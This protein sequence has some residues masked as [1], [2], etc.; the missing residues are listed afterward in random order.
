MLAFDLQQRAALRGPLSRAVQGICALVLAVAVAVAIDSFRAST[1]ALPAQTATVDRRPAGERAVDEAQ[2]RLLGA[3]E[4]PAALIRLA[5]AYLLRARETG[6]P[7]YY[8]RA[9]E[10]LSRS[11]PQQSD[12][13]ETTVALGGLALARHEFEEALEWGMQAIALGPERPSAHGILA[14]ALVELGRYDQAVGAVQRMV[15][16]RPDQPS[17]ARVSYLRE[18]HGDLP[19]AVVA[20][21]DAIAAGSPGAEATAWCEVQLGHLLFTT[22][23]LEGAELAYRGALSRLPDYVYGLAGLGRVR[24]AHGQLAEAAALY[25]QAGRSMPILELIAPLADTYLRL[26]DA[27][28][29]ARQYELFGAMSE[30]LAANGVRSDLERALF[31]ADHGL[32]LAWALDAAQREVVRR[33]TVHAF[34]TLAWAEYRLGDYAS[35]G[36]HSREAL[37]LGPSDPLM[38]YRAGVIAQAAGEPDRAYELL[39]RS[40]DLNP[41]F[42]ILWADDL[43]QRLS[44]L[45]QQEGL[46]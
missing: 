12:D 7:S 15:D 42:S 26:G 22:G 28:G 39:K 32:D 33:P 21:R 29:A 44:H 8:P 1:S 20:M 24:A 27:A 46:P 35:A 9:E 40:H 3:P 5:T 18:L 37:R 10:L 25:E 6:D 19:G 30:L 38:L 45:A 36:E 34:D 4:D 2:R 41:R 31:I 14:D 13:L 11:V 16:L 43:S 17:L 23:D